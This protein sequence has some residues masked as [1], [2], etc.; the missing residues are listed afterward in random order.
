MVK[1]LSW[2]LTWLHTHRK[3]L[4]TTQRQHS[5]DNSWD[6]ALQLAVKIDLRTIEHRHSIR[7]HRQGQARPCIRESLIAEWRKTKKTGTKRQVLGIVREWRE[8]RRERIWEEQHLE[9]KKYF[10]K[11]WEIK[12]N[13]CPFDQFEQ[14]KAWRIRQKHATIWHGKAIE[15]NECSFRPISSNKYQSSLDDWFHSFVWWK[16]KGFVSSEKGK[17]EKYF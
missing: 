12:I 1:H 2:R 3:H 4:D 11:N 5:K 10:L 8:T 14:R 7:V 6:L 16:L 17:F 15:S 9:G 13:F